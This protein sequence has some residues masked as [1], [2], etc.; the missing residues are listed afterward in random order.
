[1]GKGNR[2]GKVMGKCVSM[3]KNKGKDKNNVMARLR[4]RV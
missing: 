4:V 2:N 1:M 3:V